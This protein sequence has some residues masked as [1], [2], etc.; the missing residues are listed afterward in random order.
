[1]VS[2]K[3]TPVTTA[4]DGTPVTAPVT[5]KREVPSLVHRVKAMLKTQTLRG[6]MKVEELD[7]LIS[8]AQKMKEFAS[9]L[10]K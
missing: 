1:M 7:E 10:N 8:F 3:S 4:A 2:R 6:T 5:N 9:I